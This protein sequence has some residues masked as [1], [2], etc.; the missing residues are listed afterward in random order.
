MSSNENIKIHSE[1]SDESKKNE[2]LKLENDEE[3]KTH[4]T[5]NQEDTDQKDNGLPKET[6]QE[7][8]KKEEALIHKTE[9]DQ[10]TISDYELGMSKINNTHGEK[11][12]KGA[13][14]YLSKASTKGLISIF[15]SLLHADKF[16]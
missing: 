9:Y 11:D 3:V 7:F 12:F 6:F 5:N 15:C 16:N 10:E 2:D 1:K 4:H 14:Y 8:K 13:Y